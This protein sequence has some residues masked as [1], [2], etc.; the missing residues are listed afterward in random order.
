MAWLGIVSALLLKG[1]GGSQVITSVQDEALPSMVPL[2]ENGLSLE[3]VLLLESKMTL[4]TI[5]ISVPSALKTLL[6]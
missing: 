5:L 6:E 3:V 2:E 1:Q 4:R